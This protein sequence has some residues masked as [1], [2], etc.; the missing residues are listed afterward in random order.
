MAVA[1][2]FGR[3]QFGVPVPTQVL[4]GWQTCGRSAKRGY[5]ERP[6]RAPGSTSESRCFPQCSARVFPACAG[7]VREAAGSHAGSKPS[8]AQLSPV[9]QLV[10]RRSCGRSRIKFTGKWG[11][12]EETGRLIL[13]IQLLDGCLLPSPVLV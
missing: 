6:R 5:A 7:D 9:Q 2:D 8:S 13:A 10:L 1:I 12:H 3:P 11:E 4:A